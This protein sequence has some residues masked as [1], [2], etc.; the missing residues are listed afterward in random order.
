MRHFITLAAILIALAAPAQKQRFMYDGEKKIYYTS[1]ADAENKLIDHIKKNKGYRSFPERF[2]AYLISNDERCF[3][4]DFSRLEEVTESAA[5]AR[6]LR[7]VTSEDGMLRLYSWDIEGG[8]MSSFSG[9]TSYKDKNRIFS[10]IFIS[11]EIDMDEYEEGL[12][13]SRKIG[14]IACG[15]YDINS[16]R[17]NSGQTVYVV[18]SYASGSG[19]MYSSGLEA[20]TIGN[21]ELKEYN[22]FTHGSESSNRVSYFA[23]PCCTYIGDIM[24][25]G[26]DL[27]IPETREG[28]NPYGGDLETGRRLYYQFDGST[29]NYVGIDYPQ[30]LTKGL[31]NYKH[32]LIIIGQAPWTIRID[33][34][35]DGKARYSSWKE[36]SCKETPDIVLKNGSHTSEPKD[37]DPKQSKEI[38]SFRNG[39]YIYEISWTLD[40]M[41]NPINPKDWKVVVKRN[42]KVLMTLSGK[43]K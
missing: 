30:G 18:H 35:P 24:L 23:N 25:D 21:G 26:C 12:D 16:I 10:H 9:I 43:E 3:T 38:Y 39:E 33:I 32:N 5:T 17:L 8:T 13:K 29:F 36:K 31:C 1:V 37:G 2:F 22:L 7:V 19:I 28:Y 11:D 20:Y 40:Y 41:F 42:D 6:P 14:A 34:M 27:Y 4:Y 15:V